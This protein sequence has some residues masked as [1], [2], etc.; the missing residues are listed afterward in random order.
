MQEQD[1]VNDQPSASDPIVIAQ[2]TRKLDEF[3][4]TLSAAEFEALD[5]QL[6][7]EECEEDAEALNAYEQAAKAAVP[8]AQAFCHTTCDDDSYASCTGRKCKCKC[9]W[10]GN[11]AKC[12]CK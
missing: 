9:S 6:S 3:A 11:N 12:K 5:E 7:K 4:K 2:L 8:S 10:F 1:T